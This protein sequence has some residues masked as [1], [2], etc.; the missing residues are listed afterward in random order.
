MPSLLKLFLLILI[1]LQL[2]LIIRT[3]KSRKL[4]IRYGSFW[5]LLLLLMTIPVIF[6]EIFEIISN[7]FRFEAT[8]NMVF[9]IGFFFLFSLNFILITSISIQNE[10]IKL[11]I[12]EVSIL[13]ERIDKNG[14]EN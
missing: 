10:K 9:I 3:I 1:L 6:P 8:S 14:K 5:I 7:F 2:I 11:L 13:K 4:S 12:Q